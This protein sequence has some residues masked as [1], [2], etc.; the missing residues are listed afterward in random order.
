[1]EKEAAVEEN[2][3]AKMQGKYKKRRIV[4]MSR[5]A[6]GKLTDIARIN[7]TRLSAQTIRLEVV[8]TTIIIM[9][10]SI[11]TSTTMFMALIATTITMSI[12]RSMCLPNAFRLSDRSM[13]LVLEQ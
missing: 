7:R 12:R 6:V 4:V 13:S 1:M 3:D 10:T 5:E 2:Q 8:P 11:I 9:S